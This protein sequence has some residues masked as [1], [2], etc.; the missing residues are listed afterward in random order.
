MKV[1]GWVCVCLVALLVGQPTHGK[2]IPRWWMKVAQRQGPNACV[3]EELPQTDGLEFWTECRFWQTRKICGRKTRIRFECCEGFER[4]SGEDGCTRVKP[5][6]N[7]LETAESLGATKWAQYIRDSGLAG[8]L[9]AA[10]AYTLFA[11]TNEAFDKLRRSLRSQM[12]SYHGNPNNPILLYH[13]LPRKLLSEEFQSNTMAETRH[14]GHNIRINKYSNGMTTINCALLIRKDQHATNG[15]VH[16]I[17]NIL[18]PSVGILQ[19]VADMVLND[20]R[21]SVLAEILEKSGY[22]NVLRTMQNAITILA[23]SDEAFQKLPESRREKIINDREARLALIQ[24][25]VIPHVICESAITGEHRVKTVSDNKLTFNCDIEGAFVETSKLRGNYNLGKNGIIHMIDDVLLPDRAKNLIEL[26]ESRHLYTFVDLVKKAGLEETLSHTGDYTFFVP[27]EAAWYALDSDVL[28]DARRDLDLAGQLV[29]FHG[30]YG[31]HLTNTITDNQA[32]MSLNEEDPVRLQVWRRALGVEDAK[33]TEKD[34][35]AQNGVIHIINKVI[36]P[37]NQS[38]S[39]I[40]RSIPDHTFNTFLEAIESVTSDGSTMLSLGPGDETFYTF[41]VPTDTAFRALNQETRARIK[42]DPVYVK[43]VVKNHVAV[44]MFPATSFE[45]NLIYTINGMAGPFD[46]KKTGN[47]ILKVNGEEVLSTHMSA[48]GVIHVIDKVF[49]PGN[50]Y[51]YSTIRRV[52]TT[53]YKDGKAVPGTGMSSTSS[54][55]PSRKPY[56]KTVT[57]AE[58]NDGGEVNRSHLPAYPQG[59]VFSAS[60]SKRKTSREMSRRKNPNSPSSSTSSSSSS[61]TTST[62]SFPNDARSNPAS[63]SGRTAFQETHVQGTGAS[64]LESPVSVDSLSSASVSGRDSNDVFEPTEPGLRDTHGS[65]VSKVF[66]SRPSASN[67]DPRPIEPGHRD[68]HGSS[69]VSKDPQHRLSASNRDPYNIPEPTEPGLRD[70]HGSSSVSKDPQHRLSASN[71]DPYNIPEPTEPGLRDTHG[72]SSVSK[73]PQH[74]LSASNRD[75]YNIPEPTEPG[76]RDTHGSSSVLK[77]SQRKPSLSGRDRYIPEPIEPGLG[78]TFDSSFASKVSQRRPSGSNRDMYVTEPTE[79][80][81]RDTYDSSVSKVSQN[82]PSPSNREPYF[83]EPIEPGL[84]DTYGSSSIS[85][86][87]QSRPSIS[88]RERYVPEPTEPGLRGTYD[89]SISKTSQSR[90]SISGRDQ[91]VPEPTEPGLRDTYGSSSISET[92]QSRPSVSGRDQY[93]PEPTEPGLT[94]RYSSSNSSQRFKDTKIH[95]TN[96]PIRKPDRRTEGSYAVREGSYSSPSYKPSSSSSSSSSS[97]LATSLASNTQVTRGEVDDIHGPRRGDSSHPV[98]SSS[99]TDLHAATLPSS[100]SS[101]SSA[102]T[103][104]L[105]AT[106]TRQEGSS[107]LENDRRS[108]PD[109]NLP[110]G[111]ASSTRH[112]TR[113]TAS[114]T[115]LSPKEPDYSRGSG[116]SGRSGSPGEPGQT[117]EPDHSG[118]S[119]FQGEPGHAGRS[120][121]TGRSGSPG[122]PDHSGRS[123]SPDESGQSG[124]SGHSGRSGESDHSSRSDHSGRSGESGQSSRSDPSGRSG[125]PGHLGRSG[126]SGRS[127]EPG[128]PGEPGHLGRSD[129]L[130]RSGSPGE[131]AH[132]DR[133]D[134]SG[135]SG[136]P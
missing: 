13:I 9:E 48:N 121:Y 88:G 91:Y 38:V 89:S 27:D 78:E 108:S 105:S 97:S 3:V 79:P 41:F 18:D 129:H 39:D 76:L 85:E 75:P 65:S 124:R 28:N 49:L 7:L 125:E 26:A 109:V 83:P 53:V 106:R 60:A 94:D 113:V 136:S 57:F 12:D 59:T 21:F 14:Q 47:N 131:S 123:G 99:T 71:R 31:R 114:R 43:E 63:S 104:N 68:T 23:P 51:T 4:I 96:V 115:P 2:R 134:Y 112:S 87:S 84:R 54:R 1:W 55:R 25:H 8:E 19:N 67:R 62:P 11:P 92:S 107:T 56:R 32:I 35:E 66:Q 36:M 69:S 52:T 34:I 70:T 128:H 101:S 93:V 95:N 72:S 127:G 117:S 20:G 98:R 10:A 132:S 73:D 103:Y 80:G 111:S 126:Y 118:R 58:T 30:A 102:G 6:M 116:Y 42:S 45:K 37:S 29:R 40:L 50:S 77:V 46:V 22:I 24:N 135:R 16:L 15:V 100:S 5:L 33:I 110:A 61:T 120:V 17:N 122:E 86:V 130:G 133:S 81:L 44:N 82:R 74:R 90:P 64:V 119:S